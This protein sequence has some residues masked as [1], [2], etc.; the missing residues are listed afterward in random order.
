MAGGDLKFDQQHTCRVWYRVPAAFGTGYL[1][2]LSTPCLLFY[3][4]Y[5]LTLNIEINHPDS[6]SLT[7]PHPDQPALDE[8]VDGSLPN[9][10]G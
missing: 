6:F 7:S 8:I 10:T 1:P 9:M 2:R 3:I 5:V 4:L